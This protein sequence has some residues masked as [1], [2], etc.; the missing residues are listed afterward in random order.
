MLWWAQTRTVLGHVVATVRTYPATSLLVLLLAVSVVPRVTSWAQSLG[1]SAQ[2]PLAA[3]AL[4]DGI[5]LGGADAE[6]LASLREDFEAMQQELATTQLA[7]AEAHRA[8]EAQERLV[9]ATEEQ[10]AARTVT[11]ARVVLGH[12]VSPWRRSVVIDRGAKHGLRV[13]NPVVHG[14]VLLGRVE[15]V[16]PVTSRVQLLTDPGV[17]GIRIMVL[18]ADSL[19]SRDVKGAEEADLEGFPRG[20]ATGCHRSSFAVQLD[21]VPLDAE[22]AEGDLVFTSHQSAVVPGGLIV[23]RIVEVNRSQRREFASVR[24]EPWGDPQKLENVQVLDFRIELE[25]LTEGTR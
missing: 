21:F 20:I 16:G 15:A 18:P 24:V 14:R 8:L 9:R 13:G 6:E 11:S 25:G 12:D 17:R 19:A 4:L 22:I 2:A 7:L 5:S 10:L 3:I 23:G 1:A